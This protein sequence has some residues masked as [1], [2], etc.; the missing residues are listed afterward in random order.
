MSAT[1]TRVIVCCGSGGVGKTTTSAALALSLA[2][3]GHRVAVLTIDPARRLADS[4]GIGPLSNDPQRVPLEG[5]HLDA[6]ML[7]MKAT[8][9]G[10]IH[11]FAPS[12]EARDRILANRY[13][14]LASTRLAG[15]HEFMAMQRLYELAE[16]GDYDV[17]LLDT[18]P[19]RHALEF[20]QAPSRLSGLFDEGV[21]TW[22]SMPR[23]SRGMK[24]LQRGSEVVAGI[25]ERLLGRGTIR[26]IAQFFD[27]MQGLWVGFQERSQAV[28]ELLRGEGTQFLLVTT[29]APAARAEAVA[30]LQRLREDGL[31]FGGFLVN[32]VTPMPEPVTVDA[33]P[34]GVDAADWKHVVHGLHRAHEVWS[35]VAETE[36]G[37]LE[38]LLQGRERLWLIP[39]QPRDVH[40]LPALR[41]LAMKLPAQDFLP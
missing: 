15:S 40:D 4:L 7:D 26:E 3:A 30:F 10:V 13:Y 38:A 32:R 2:D 41:E 9:D 24:A 36:K 20:L 34:Q 18:P 35:S 8:W 31:P 1:N 6:M 16:S 23:N 37:W 17:V 21:M 12:P 29:P 14:R 11:R 28:E 27:S 19:S 22:I 25:L 5:M 33:P 39:E